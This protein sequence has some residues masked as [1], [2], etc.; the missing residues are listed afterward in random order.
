L[1]DFDVHRCL[2]ESPVPGIQAGSL[3]GIY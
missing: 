3:C 2:L 1:G